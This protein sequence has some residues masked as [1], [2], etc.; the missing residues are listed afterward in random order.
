MADELIIKNGSIVEG[1]IAAIDGTTQALPT[2]TGT[3]SPGVTSAPISSRI[4]EFGFTGDVLASQTAGATLAVGQVCYLRTNG[5]WFT[6]NSAQVATGDGMLGIALNA[7]SATGG[8]DIFTRGIIGTNIDILTSVSSGIGQ[9]IYLNTTNGTMSQTAPSSEN[10][11]VRILG[12]Y[13]NLVSGQTE[14]YVI[15][16]NPDSIWL[17]L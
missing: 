5:K 7:A 13:L 15:S 11:I 17:E 14:K 4:P 8:V 12:Y 2:S 1:S 16:F 10:N 9:P 6:A 3:I